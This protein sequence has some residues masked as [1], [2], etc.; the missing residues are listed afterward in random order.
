VSQSV[1]SNLAQALQEALTLHRQGQFGRAEK[2]YARILKAR[3]DHFDALHLLGLL[4]H[5]TGKAGEAYRLI[6]AALAVN[7]RSA[8]ALAN[9]GLVLHALKRDA[10]ALA[11][12][13]KALALDPD[14][15]EALNNRGTALLELDRPAEALAA[16][17]RLLK[18]S[19]RHLE[20]QVNRANALLGLDRAEDAIAGY[21]AV[22]AMQPRHA[23][24]LFN[25]GNALASLDR[26]AE[27]IAAY[28]RAIAIVPGYVK[29]HN[30][31]GVALRA[32]NRHR[33]ALASYGKAIALDKDFADAHLNE[34]HALL[35]LGD[36]RR[37]F[38]AY[39]W[40]W[41]VAA[42]APHRR[43][44]RQPLWLGTHPIARKTILLHAEQ[45]LGDTIQFARYAG[46]LA[47]AGADV[48]LEVAPALAT[49]LS[50]IDGVRVL[51]PGA[52]LPAFD[53]RCPL[54]SLPLALKTEL[55]GIPAEVPYLAAPAERLA[56]WRPRMDALAR[57]RIAL[58]WSGSAAHANDR[59]RSIALARLQP[60]WSIDGASFV[61]VQ[62]DL[63]E[64]D[65]ALARA[66]RLIHVGDELADFADT[67]AVLALADLVISVDSAVAHLAGALGRPLWILLPFSPDWRW[68]L[69]RDDSPWYPTA[70]LFRQPSIG[71]W[72][73]VIERVRAELA[74]VASSWS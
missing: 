69:E 10:D 9:L 35:T 73:S 24:A 38:E 44:F 22:L 13:D 14:H 54:A 26:F 41:K 66:P 18:L 39:E 46:P 16:F 47:R 19:P 71:D 70:R 43:P 51:A 4:K 17:N 28:D 55:A 27:A 23:G 48:V 6:T 5:Q 50:G 21:D 37:G 31:R 64:E 52:A 40:R 58:A 34:A 72:E 12:F 60:L 56:K 57:P 30:N 63:R 7:P 61:S 74:R 32:L 62:R 20:A 33:E 3:R 36:L 29:A 68:M 2:I 11:S 45:G 25:R 67:A 42:L 59:N 65:A 8:D 49:L 53:V 15:V 1:A